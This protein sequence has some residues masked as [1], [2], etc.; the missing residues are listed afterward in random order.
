MY[1]AKAP[2]INRPK[3]VTIGGEEDLGCRSI[4]TTTANLEIRERNQDAA[5][6][7]RGWELRRIWRVEAEIVGAMAGS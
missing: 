5:A 7:W 4:T 6:K 2:P 1:G 3:L